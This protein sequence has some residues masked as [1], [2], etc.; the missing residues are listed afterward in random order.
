MVVI[1][2]RKRTLVLIRSLIRMIN[3]CLVRSFGS[4]V[5]VHVTSMKTVVMCAMVPRHLRLVT[6]KVDS[7]TQQS[8]SQRML[9]RRF[10]LL[11]IFSRPT[12]K[13]LNLQKDMRSTS[14]WRT[15][16]SYLQMTRS[17]ISTSKRIIWITYQ[18]TSPSTSVRISSQSLYPSM[19][20]FIFLMLSQMHSR[21]Y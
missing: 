13:R 1:I 5:H 8:C 6:L 2:K 19:H 10:C 16:H 20:L 4:E 17:L 11:N 12:Q 21:K 9:V 3:Q 7:S 14:L 18:R 15:Q